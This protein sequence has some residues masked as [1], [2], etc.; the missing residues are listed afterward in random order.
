MIPLPR[1]LHIS[2]NYLRL[3]KVVWLMKERQVIIFVKSGIA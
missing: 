3:N 1:E 2:F